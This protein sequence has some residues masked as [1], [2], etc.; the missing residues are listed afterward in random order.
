MNDFEEFP[1][2]LDVS[3]WDGSNEPV[4]DLKLNSSITTIAYL[5]MS[6]ELVYPVYEFIDWFFRPLLDI[7]KL[8]YVNLGGDLFIQGA[9]KIIE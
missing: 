6:G 2:Q 7:L 5:H 9:L 8:I 4:L 1:L 3:I